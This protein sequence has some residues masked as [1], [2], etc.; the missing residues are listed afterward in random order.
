[1]FEK[2]KRPIVKFLQLIKQSYI[3]IIC[4]FI[5]FVGFDLIDSHYSGYGSNE[6]KILGENIRVGLKILGGSILVG[7]SLLCL[8]LN[9]RGKK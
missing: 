4:I 1:M 7:S 8:T 6:A 3:F 5:I 2:T 9:T